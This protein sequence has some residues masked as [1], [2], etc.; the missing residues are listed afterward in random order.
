MRF[1]TDTYRRGALERIQEARLLKDSGQ[2]TGSMYLAGLAVEG[3]LRSIIW[4]REKSFDS[5]HMLK[6][7]A[8]RIGDLGLPRSGGRDH[9]FVGA[10]EAV[11][12]RWSNDLR[13]ADDQQTRRWL[14]KMGIIQRSDD[15][16]KRLCTEHYGRCSEVVRRCEVLWTRHRKRS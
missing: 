8:T 3:M 14:F 1:G 5:R 12:R 9:D 11:A 4:L 2:H 7:I 10:V 6:E 13:F 16:L 15:P